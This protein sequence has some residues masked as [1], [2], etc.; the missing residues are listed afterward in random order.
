MKVIDVI[1]EF[2]KLVDENGNDLNVDFRIVAP[3]YVCED[4]S[5]DISINYEGAI[6]TSLLSEGWVEIGFSVIKGYEKEFWEKLTGLDYDKLLKEET[7]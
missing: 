2:Q 5:M 4:D 1:K 7:V 3:E 6:G